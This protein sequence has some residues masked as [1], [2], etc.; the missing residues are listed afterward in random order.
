MTNNFL[1]QVGRTARDQAKLTAKQVI[2]EPIEI[3]KEGKTHAGLPKDVQPQSGMSM[4]QEVMTGGGHAKELSPMEEMSINAEAKQR[5][6]EI[7]AELRQLR[8]QRE[9]NAMEWTKEQNELMKEPGGDAKREFV[10]PSG[11]KKRGAQQGGQKKGGT[12][13][14]TKQHKG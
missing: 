4:M 12:G 13:E 9:Q 3:F 14:I 2:R 6:A 8:Q 5:L 10:M 11:A 7:E 1:K